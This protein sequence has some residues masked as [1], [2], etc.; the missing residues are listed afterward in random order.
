MAQSPSHKF[1]QQLGKLL[2]DIV[3]YDIL[4]PRLQQ[5][6]Q[7]KNYYLDWQRS[8]PAR[9]GKKVTWKD[10]YGNRHD[11]DFVIEVDGTDNK[12]GRPVAFIESAWRRYT[13]HSK[14]KAQ[15]IQ[16]AIL[17]IIELHHL[18]A[19]FYGVV[20]AGDFTKPALEQL[21]NNGFA[22]I[23]IPYK[24]VV[25]AF[26]VIDFDVAFD[27]DTPDESYTTA[28]R[29]LDSLTSSDKE[30]LRQAL[31]RVSQEEVDRF[32]ETLRNCLER[33]IRNIILIPLF[34]KRY[35]F[36]SIDD[37]ISRLDTLKIDSPVGEFEKFE[38]IVDYNNSDTIR[39]TF[40]NKNLL[41]DFLIKLE[42]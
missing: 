30:K 37:A 16:G 24:S 11:L 1:G 20:L 5:F 13:K 36:D 40:Q 42:H 17:P 14:N 19:P 6:A 28:F 34:G 9:S 39:A 3:L 2:E 41:T 8:R 35:E 7:V 26:Q 27:E 32:M 15:E 25:S 12:L 33:F 10:K 22:V 23:Y 21:K 18:S 29:Q 38:V 4:K 31:M